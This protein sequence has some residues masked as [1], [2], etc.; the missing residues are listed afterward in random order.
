MSETILT[1]NLIC[2][3]A[4]TCAALDDLAVPDPEDAIEAAEALRKVFSENSQKCRTKSVSR[5]SN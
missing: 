5:S 2:V 3:P 1:A 4:L